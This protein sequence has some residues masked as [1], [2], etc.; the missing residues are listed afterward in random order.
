M[1]EDLLITPLDIIETPGGNVMHV[2]REF[3]AGYTNFGEAYF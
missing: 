3:D 2:M 1:I